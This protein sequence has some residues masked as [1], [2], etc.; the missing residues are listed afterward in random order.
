MTIFDRECSNN[1][2]FSRL[3]KE[4]IPFSV[5]AKNVDKDALNSMD[6]KLFVN[7]LVFNNKDYSYFEEPKQVN[8]KEENGEVFG[9]TLR[10]INL[11]NKTSKR[12]TYGYSWSNKSKYSTQDCAE[13]ILLRWGAS[14][15][16]FKH[17]NAKHPFK[18]H[19]GFS[20]KLSANQ[21]IKNPKIKKLQKEIEQ[22]RKEL[23]KFYKKL[24][25]KGDNET[26]SRKE[27]K[28]KIEEYEKDL[29]KIQDQ[30]KNEPE[31]I[32]ISNDKESKP[33]KTIQNEG[34]YLFD[35][36]G[37]SVWNV[38][39]TMTDWMRPYFNNENELVDLVY[40]IINCHG[41]IKSTKNEVIV[42]LEPLEQKKRKAAQIQFC[43]K[44]TNKR[45]QLPSGKFIKIEVGE[46]PK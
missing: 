1:K 19:P 23:N 25:Q 32:D 6:E 17:I 35:F 16:T 43:K 27:L 13:A 11:W 46:S 21:L 18:Y 39:K 9:F 20:L 37:I 10:K 5:W 12:K 31:K 4:G 34:K 41:W 36:V 24:S 45:A 44:L 28:I 42:R 15:N 2:C 33:F 40:A 8:Y 38:R 26:K 7:N 29:K 14:E 30:K 3:I 22:Y